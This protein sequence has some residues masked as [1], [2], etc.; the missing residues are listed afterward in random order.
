MENVW[1]R[2]RGLIDLADRATVT[3]TGLRH[4]DGPEV[5][6]VLDFEQGKC[7]R[8]DEGPAPVKEGEERP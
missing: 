7:V 4:G 2:L 8:C 3:I 6:V 1:V 5:V